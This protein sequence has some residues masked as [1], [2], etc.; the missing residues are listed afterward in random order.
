MLI[1]D[2]LCPHVKLIFIF[3]YT[4]TIMKIRNFIFGSVLTLIAISC[5]K[6]IIESERIT[7]LTQ[8][9]AGT[10]G[11]ISYVSTKGNDNNTG[12]LAAPYLTI[13]KAVDSAIAG[14][15]I[16]VREGTYYPTTAITFYLHNGTS[17][18]PIQLMAYPGE[19]PVIDGGV[20]T[21]ANL[22]L[23]WNNYINM[24]GFEL[25]NGTGAGITMIGQHCTVG[26]MI[27]HDF[28]GN[29][30]TANGDYSVVEDCLVYNTAMSNYAN[31]G[32]GINGS[33]ISACRGTQTTGDMTTDYAIIR[34]NIV[35]DIWGEGIS[36]FEATYSTMEDNTMYNGW[37]ANIYISDATHILCQ[38]NLVYQT[39]TMLNGSQ[40]GI[41]GGDE[42]LTPPSSYNTFVCNIVYGCTRNFT[43]WGSNGASGM[44][45]FVIANN[46]FVSA[47][48]PA[49]VWLINAN[50]INT[51]F[52]NNI[53]Y[54]PSG[55][56]PPVY[57]SGA[58]PG[59]TYSNNLWLN[60]PKS[61]YTYVIGT[62]DVNGDPLFANLA[63]PYIA[64]SY[65]L[66]GSSPAINKGVNVGLTSD[67]L[68]NPITGLPDIGAYE[69]TTLVA[70][71]P[72]TYYNAQATASATK[73]SC[74]AGY[75]GST[76]TYTVAA[77]KYSSTTSQADAD[78]LAATDLNTNTQTYANTNGTCT[79]VPV[80]YNT[81]ISSTATKN[82]CGA[83]Y[84]GSTVTYTVA[85]GKYNST[86]SQTAA[87]NLATTDL[88]TNTQTYA[89]TN[90][91]CTLIPV[92][93]N[94][95][96]SATATKNSCG[97]GYTGSTVTYTV[98]AGKYSS[99]VSQATA[100]NL[101][102]ADLS[103]NTQTYANAN[104][105]CTLIPVYYNTPLS[106]TA[107][108]NSCGAGY[109]G[110][111]VTYTVAAG[112]YNST[113][114]QA[115]A[116]NLATADL[117]SN[118][119][120]YANANGTCTLIPVYYNTQL[121]ATATKNSCGAGYTGS[122]VTYTVAAGKYNSTVSQATADNLAAT[123]LNTNTQTYANANGTCAAI[124]VYYNTQ[125]SATTTKNSCGSGYTGST[126]TYTVG[127]AKYS[128]T[129]SQTTADNL[130]ATDLNA[131]T[132]TY[133]N[134]N[135]TCTAIPVYYNVTMSA[136][137]TKNNCGRGLT[138]SR[139]T[140][141]VAAR[142]Y[143]STVSQSAANRLATSDLNANKQA[144]AN[145]NGTCSSKYLKTGY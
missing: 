113:V 128:S 144:Y 31:P 17:V 66:N 145:S 48:G 23:T 5:N 19:Y 49:N 54:Q 101:A 27:V 68:G 75:T 74:G 135:G 11:T 47:T 29:G 82:S 110:S 28:S 36:I 18:S 93:Y 88:S 63:S 55:S 140:Y 20:C 3:N 123:D 12:T 69:Y 22:I 77:G 132:Q 139:V 78:N 64:E 83:G 4:I 73:N 129:V 91:T 125:I 34:R 8:L 130:A 65:Q 58:T 62:G 80:Y 46:T 14:D 21:S 114:S 1:G 42:K 24:T 44:N 40:I 38:R 127:A 141:T 45:N 119:Q 39:K 136:T 76:V 85:A 116:N 37:S 81:Q 71:T 86:V 99:T 92:Y 124:P 79:L 35:H 50:A 121:S 84:T 30:I 32:S 90:G 108:K 41:M 59:I 10:I 107:T 67:Y 104:G 106:A 105:T 126:V 118:T 25:R 16:Y 96:I 2:F 103:S 53:V 33:G 6:N 94:T 26:H 143:S 70:A 61:P 115:A 133:A 138:G 9:K 131:N 15:T 102:T 89:N 137:V 52:K 111:T 142:T 97:A 100:D 57:V 87:D 122:T 72:T 120:T 109:T 7:P 117:T 60:Y 13:Q 56:T 95:Q 112:K 43:F 98:A 51:I 134:T